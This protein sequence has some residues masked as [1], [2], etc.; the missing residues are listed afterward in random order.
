MHEEDQNLSRRRPGFPVFGKDRTSEAFFAENNS[1]EEGLRPF[2][3]CKRR[4]RIG[5]VA[6]KWFINRGFLGFVSDFLALFYTKTVFLTKKEGRIN[7]KAVFGVLFQ[8]ERGL[9]PVLTA[10]WNT[11]VTPKR[12]SDSF[13]HA[14]QGLSQQQKNCLNHRLSS[15][16]ER[17]R[18][19]RALDIT[20]DPAVPSHHRKRRWEHDRQSTQR[21]H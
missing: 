12:A 8:S 14:R 11:E 9:L 15:I 7:R 13:R 1:D 10:I 21:G 3:P 19:N 17:V 6:R 4:G 2:F 16:G 5:A 20:E 18:Q